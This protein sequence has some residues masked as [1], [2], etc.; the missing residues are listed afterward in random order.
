[1]ITLLTGAPGNG[2]GVYG[3]DWLM[4]RQSSENKRLLSE[5]KPERPVYYSGITDCKVPGWIELDDPTKWYECPPGSFILI[6]ECQRVFRTRANGAP[7]PQHVEELETHRH[8]GYDL[9]LDTQHPMLIDQNVRR[10]VGQHFHI[11]RKFGMEKAVVHE[12][13]KVVE[14]PHKSRAGSVRHDYTFNKDVYGLYKSA[15]I[16]TVKRNVPF[17]YYLVFI[18]PLVIIGVLVAA[19]YSMTSLGDKAVTVEAQAPA[20]VPA[21]AAASRSPKEEPKLSYFDARAPRVA[22]FPA[23]A[24]VYDEITKPVVAPVPAACVLSKSKGCNCYTQQATPLQVDENTCRQ[25]VAHGYFQ[26]FD[27]GT[28]KD[29]QQPVLTE[30]PTER[31]AYEAPEGGEAVAPAPVGVAVNPPGIAAV[32]PQ[33]ERIPPNIVRDSMRNS[34][35][36]YKPPSGA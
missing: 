10:L 33:Q 35:W 19:Y 14:Q 2:K 21:Q 25:I 28:L 31:T 6:A 9:L 13:N 24:P 23:T 4:T 36:A 22:A 3:I 32:D 26:D 30:T 29:K 12:W 15:E 7:V 5:G 1:M 16:H 27:N 20:E 11:M 34:Q 17:R 8:R 18:I